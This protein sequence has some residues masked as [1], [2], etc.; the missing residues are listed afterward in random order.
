MQGRLINKGGFFPQTFPCSNWE[1]EFATGAGKE[2]KYM[3]WMFNAED[4]TENPI[5]NKKGRSKIREMIAKTGLRVASVC[6]NYCMKNTIAHEGGA[7]GK[8]IKII[9]RLMDYADDIGADTVVI[10]LFGESEISH[11]NM[12]I[13]PL[14]KILENGNTNVRVALEGDFEAQEWIKFMSKVNNTH[15]GI[16][17]DVGNAAGWGHNVC[18]DVRELA[19]F[20]FEFHLKDKKKGGNSV[21]L[22]EGDVPFGELI[23]ILGTMNY[24]GTYILESYFDTNASNDTMK[25]HAFFLNAQAQG[26]QSLLM[27]ELEKVNDRQNSP[28]SP[29]VCLSAAAQFSHMR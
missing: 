28:R 1:D 25:N 15:V 24:R 20:I 2:L 7:L 11:V 5:W 12:I 3:E 13:E 4:F 14:S 10:P 6:A 23:S 19:R 21:M 8:N 26:R 16:C 27:K 22:G 18:K 17:Y 9:S 29:I